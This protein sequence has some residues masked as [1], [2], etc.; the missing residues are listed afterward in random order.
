MKI[1]PSIVSG[2][3]LAL[4]LQALTA[5]VTYRIYATREGLVGNHT[6]NGHLIVSRDH[7]VALPSGTTLNCNGCSTYRVTVRNI[8]TG[9][10]VTERQYDVGP[11]NTKD[12]Y[13]H[14]PRQMWTSLPRGLPEAQAAYQDNFNGGKDEF[15]RFVSNPAGI[16][17]ADGTFWDSLGLSGNTWIDVTFLW[18]TPPGTAVTVDNSSANFAASASWSTGTGATD[19]FGSDYRYRSTA[20]ISDP[21]TWTGNLPSTKTW[22]VYAWWSQGSNR[23]STASYIVANNAGTVT[24]TVNQQANGGRWNLLGSW[25][26]GGSKTTKLSCWTTTGFVVLADAVKW[27]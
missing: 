12:N 15:G 17:L 3:F 6:A 20:P 9:A 18:E 22:G 11:W 13:W 19:K 16:D 21:A 27:Q 10:S 24:V 26:M 8:S 5:Q 4:S 2:L 25:S 1:K 7:F 23:S 14:V